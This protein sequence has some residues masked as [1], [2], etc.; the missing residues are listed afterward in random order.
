MGIC[1]K[2]KVIKCQWTAQNFNWFHPG[3]GCYLI[4]TGGGV[5][6]HSQTEFNRVSKSFKF[7]DG[8]L[9]LCE[10]DP[11]QWKLRFIKNGIENFEF[12]I[13]PPP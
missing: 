1:L 7:E 2:S 13:I 10:Y 5:Y 9:I 12:S 6:S 11:I 4:G 3:H 8:D